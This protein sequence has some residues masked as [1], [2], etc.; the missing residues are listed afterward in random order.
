MINTNPPTPKTYG[1]II[2]ACEGSALPVSEKIPV[3]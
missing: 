1:E 2:G 3:V